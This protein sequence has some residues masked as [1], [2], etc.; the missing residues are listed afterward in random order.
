MGTLGAFVAGAGTKK[1]EKEE[2]A[3]VGEGEGVKEVVVETG[4]QEEVEVGKK[5]YSKEVQVL[6]LTQEVSGVRAVELKE[7]VTY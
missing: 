1:E 2:E 3:E 4:D 6:K 7:V 5:M